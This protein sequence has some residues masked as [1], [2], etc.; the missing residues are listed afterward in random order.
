ME[1]CA[2]CGMP[3]VPCA[4]GYTHV[5][6]GWMVEC[7]DASPTRTVVAESPVAT[8]RRAEKDKAT[9]DALTWLIAAS[10]EVT[11]G[12]VSRGAHSELRVALDLDDGPPMW[13]GDL[14][15]CLLAAKE[16]CESEGITP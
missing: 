4:V 13:Y 5:P 10:V 2:N 11:I 8:A 16:Y 3:I 9:A 15:T 1:K 12:V 14:T 6:D 7:N